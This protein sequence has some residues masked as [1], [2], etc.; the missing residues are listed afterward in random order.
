MTESAEYTIRFARK[1]EASVVLAIVH[2][3][4]FWLEQRGIPLWTAK[5]LDPVC[6]IADV[7]AGHYVLASDRGR[8][9]GVLRF[10]LEDIDFWPE[11]LPGEA[12]YVHRLAVRRSHAGKQLPRMML[13]WAEQHSA[14]LG[15]TW[16]RLDCEA[17]RPKLKQL[18]EGL[19]F[20]FHSE[21]TL[22]D[23]VVARYQRRVSGVCV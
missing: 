19:G 23:L 2:E 4:S 16:L 22:G 12:G 6:T 11:A 17:A 5:E 20:V 9:V 3:A 15:R 10:T 13:T 18:Y 14:S 21:H 7:E 8:A 1:D